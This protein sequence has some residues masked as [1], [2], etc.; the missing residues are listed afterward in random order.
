MFEK[1]LF[2]ENIYCQTKE[3]ESQVIESIAVLTA[4]TAVEEFG[5]L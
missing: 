1:S 3:P 5:E 4:K 2:T